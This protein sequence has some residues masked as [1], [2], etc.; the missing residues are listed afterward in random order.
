MGEGRRC[1]WSCLIR[2]FSMPRW[3]QMEKL[4]L[5]ARRKSAPMVVSSRPYYHIWPYHLGHKYHI[6]IIL[7][8]IILSIRVLVSF[9]RRDESRELQ[10]NQ[11]L[12]LNPMTCP[13]SQYYSHLL[14]HPANPPYHNQIDPVSWKMKTLLWSNTKECNLI[15]FCFSPRTICNFSYSVMS[16]SS[17]IRRLKLFEVWNI[18]CLIWQGYLSVNCLEFIALSE[19]SKYPWM[20]TILPITAN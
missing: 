15:L 9:V 8:S 10:W 2:P 3:W 17:P 13:Y 5:V 12:V 1:F 11:V 19:A 6:L 20:T 16:K 7:Q 18:W 4:L 14:Q